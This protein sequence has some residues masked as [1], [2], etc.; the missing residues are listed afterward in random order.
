MPTLVVDVHAAKSR[1]SELL[2]QVEAGTDIIITRAGQP[3]AKL[4]PWPPTQPERKLD[5]LSGKIHIHKHDVIGSDPY[6][7]AAFEASAIAGLP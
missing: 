7:V 4:I 1:L 6:M 2:Q 3:V 5:F